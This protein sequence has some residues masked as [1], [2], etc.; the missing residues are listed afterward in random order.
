M[1]SAHKRVSTIG[2]RKGTVRELR[3][4]SLRRIPK[5]GGL[6]FGNSSYTAATRKALFSWRRTEVADSGTVSF[7]LRTSVDKAG[8]ED[9]SSH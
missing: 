1:S 8:L 2:Q 6:A 3:K 5:A 7:P 4:A 9:A